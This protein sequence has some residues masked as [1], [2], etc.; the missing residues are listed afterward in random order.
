MYNQNKTKKKLSRKALAFMISV[1]VVAVV[2]LTGLIMVLTKGKQIKDTLVVMPFTS[3]SDPTGL[4]ARKCSASR[5]V[6]APS[7]KSSGESAP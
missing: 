2:L 4:P 7:L 6:A 5:W 3:S 1:I